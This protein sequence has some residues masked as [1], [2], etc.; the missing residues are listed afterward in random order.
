MKIIFLCM[1]VFRSYII[2]GLLSMII[3]TYCDSR[4]YEPIRSYIVL[5]CFYFNNYYLLV[6]Y[7]TTN[8]YH[9]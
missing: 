3:I 6:Y 8:Y 1:I 7:L 5:F 9:I 4:H 2:Y